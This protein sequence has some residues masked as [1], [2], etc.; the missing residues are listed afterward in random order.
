LSEWQ[1][2]EP[3]AAGRHQSPVGLL[4]QCEQEQQAA[5]C[6]DDVSDPGCE[7]TVEFDVGEQHLL[8]VGTAAPAD[9]GLYAHRAAD[10][11]TAGD[12]TRDH[13]LDPGGRA[14]GRL[15][16]VRGA[17]PKSHELDAALDFDAAVGERAAQDGF[18]VQLP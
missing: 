8:P 15:R 6:R 5:A 11:V 16:T 10:A 3:G 1:R 17:Y 18:D 12:R 2:L 9:A 14:E 4:A 7:I 13:L